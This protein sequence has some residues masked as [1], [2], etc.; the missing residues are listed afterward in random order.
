MVMDWIRNVLNSPVKTDEEKDGDADM[1]PTGG[2]WTNGISYD[3]ATETM[4]ISFNDGFTATYEHVSQN[5]AERIQAGATTKDGRGNSV[6]AA[7]HRS[8][9]YS[10]YK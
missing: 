2:K 5:E 7:L 6:G 3:P 1:Q 8:G 10:Q 4:K 9:H